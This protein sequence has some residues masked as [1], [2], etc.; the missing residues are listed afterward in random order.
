MAVGAPPT[1]FIYP[2]VTPADIEWLA[3]FFLTPLMLPTPVATRLPRAN[4]LTDT[5]NGFL[6]VEAGGG[7]KI[8]LTEFNQTILLHTYTPFEFEVLGAEIAN[9][10]IAYMAAATGLNVSGRYVSDVSHVSAV[11][12]RTD[13][14]VNLLHYLSFV[15]WR[16]VGQPVAQ[17]LA[18]EP[19]LRV[20]E[21][22][23]NGILSAI[24]LTE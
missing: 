24:A 4:V 23:G 15:T 19:I 3:T 1:G 8:N 6:R 12:R 20:P 17:A 22:S 2:V 13:P 21:L 18:P 16:V 7:V 10:A 9:K 5:Q 14:N 11:Q